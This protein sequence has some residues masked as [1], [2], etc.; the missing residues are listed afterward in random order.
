MALKV[1][2][3]G[4]CLNTPHIR[5]MGKYV[6]EILQQ[7]R[8]CSDLS[9]VV[10]GD[11]LRYPLSV[12]TAAHIATDVFSFRGDRLFLWEQIG[13]PLRAGRHEVNLVHCTEGTLSLWQPRPTVVTVHDTLMWQ[14]HAG[15]R[16]EAFY[17]DTLLPAALK[18]CAAVIT[19][20]ESSRSD[21]LAK[22]PWL[23]TR[24]HV[25]PQGISA[26]YFADERLPV[27]DIL[28]LEI[29]DAPYVVYFGGP[30]ERKRFSW[31]LD[32][33]AHCKHAT[34]KLIA[35]G[36]GVDARR[37]AEEALPEALRGRV[38][39]AP[40]LSDSDLRALSGGA[41]AVLYPTLYE[42]FGFP[43]VEAQAL[44]VP[45]IFSALGSLSELIGPLALVVPP[46]DLD[47]WCAAL[48]EAL[49]MGEARFEKAL[50]ARA[51]ARRFSWAESFSKHLAVY[52]QA[53]SVRTVALS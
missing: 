41:R 23:E 32:V 50:A 21:I 53:A 8:A 10:F 40:F 52:R 1:G 42:G 47:A 49:A 6:Y 17:L 45:V 16:I 44:G 46:H 26:E 15:G 13:L 12:P 28:Q 29:G 36:F 43:A 20:S 34:M 30:M 51:W 22:W 38:I 3:V 24:L 11:D 48:S 4:R 14:E 7:S 39:F 35:C 37:A 5:G 25:I 2:L 31:A 27:P 19:I 18:R 9:W 33:V